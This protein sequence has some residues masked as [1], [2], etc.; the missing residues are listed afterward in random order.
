ML[1]LDASSLEFF[2]DRLGDG[3]FLLVL[4]VLL[5]LEE[6]D[7]RTSGASDSFAASTDC[8]LLC[9]LTR[10]ALEAGLLVSSSATLL[11]S[12]DDGCCN[13]DDSDSDPSST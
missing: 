2:D 10:V 11:G 9:S 1:N 4:L 5:T 12:A 13:L 7:V 6:D 8:L 3:F